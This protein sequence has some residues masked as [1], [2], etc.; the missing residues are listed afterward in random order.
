MLEMGV[1]KIDKAMEGLKTRQSYMV[2]QA[3]DLARSLG[4]LS[5]LQHR[6]LDYCFSFVRK[7]DEQDKIYSARLLDVLHHLGLASSGPNYRRV[8]EAF[9]ALNEKTALYMPGK[10][11]DGSSGL[12]MTSLFDRIAIGR[13]NGRVEFRFSRDA[14][15]LVF[16]LHKNFYSFR[17][18]ELT[19][20]KS[21]YTLTMMK[22]W[23]ARG[24][25]QWKPENR[26]L[27][28]AII[29]GSLEEWEAWF[30]GS[31]KDGNPKRWPAGRFNQK[32]LSVALKELDN[33]Y[34]DVHYKLLPIKNSRKVV[35][36]RL[37]IIPPNEHVKTER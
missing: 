34:P 18:A 29:E 16:Q 32:V 4:N 1:K 26:Q 8:I 27:P 36:Y 22:L 14:E 5:S 17:L 21:K 30:I 24:W 7:E 9:K 15:P 20:V 11:Q 28:H 12:V 13:T 6:V 3:N 25:G 19:G 33:M 37:E 23:N 2:T 35:G 31:D 10:M